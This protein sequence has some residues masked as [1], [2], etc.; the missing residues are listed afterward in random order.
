MSAIEIVKVT[1]KK[2]LKQFIDFNH[3]LY[4]KSP[5]A[6][7]EIREDMLYTLD[8]KQ[9]EAFEFCDC[10]CYLA[11]RDGKVVGRVAAIINRKANQKWNVKVVRFGWIDFIDDAEVARKLLE[12]V[13]AFGRAHGMEKIQ[14]PLGFTDFDPEGTLIEGFDELDTMGTLY[15]YD[16]YPRIFEQLGFEKAVDWVEQIIKMP[17]HIPEKHK[18]VAELISK[19]YNLTVRSL[20]N[21]KTSRNSAP[22]YS[23]SSTRPI[24]SSS[25][26]P[27]CRPGRPPITSAN[28]CRQST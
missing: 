28:T 5:Y 24:P 18:R 6:A 19:R 3:Q 1:D 27:K 17:T 15:N 21:K 14:G 20:R 2:G 4:K 16:Y 25:A 23:V 10:E 22:R 8:P 7:P 12:Q 11:K 9:N 13:E 26:T